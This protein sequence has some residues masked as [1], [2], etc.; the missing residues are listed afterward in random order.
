[1]PRSRHS[2]SRRLVYSGALSYEAEPAN[3]NS[4]G[5]DTSA[6]LD[7]LTLASPTALGHPTFGTIAQQPALDSDSAEYGQAYFAS[8]QTTIDTGN[9]SGAS[10]QR[11]PPNPSN[12][13]PDLLCLVDISSV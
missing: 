7:E 2:Q 10:R 3:L 6:G 5:F 13:R 11:S 4:Y 12:I 8:Y 9:I 1:M